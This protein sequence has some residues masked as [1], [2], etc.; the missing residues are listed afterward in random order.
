[1]TVYDLI[2]NM[3][4]DQTRISIYYGLKEEGH[5]PYGIQGRWFEDRILE[6]GQREVIECTWL[7]RHEILII[8]IDPL[9]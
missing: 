1:M 5:I 9:G 6:L 7:K 3:C 2:E 4:T 8:H